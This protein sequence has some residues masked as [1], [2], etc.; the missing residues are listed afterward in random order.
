MLFVLLAAVIWGSSFPVINY[1]LRDISP[2]LFLTLRFT[3]AFLILLPFGS[4]SRTLRGLFH[5]DLFLLS[6]PSVLAFI[7]QFKGQ[8]LTTASKAALFVNSTPVH[9]AIVSWL[10]FRDR[11][12]RRQVAATVIALVGVVVTSTKLDFSTLSVI[13]RGD[14]YCAVVGVCWGVFIVFSIPVVKKY[15]A[16]QLSR[17]LYFWTAVLALPFLSGEEMRF[18]VAALPAVVYL[19]GVTT[20]LAYFLYLKG[21]AR[22]SSLST[23]IIILVEVVVAFAI[24]HVWLGESFTALE[25][26]GVILV[27]VG[28]TMVPR[29]SGGQSP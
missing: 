22:V 15:G 1:S 18:G 4:P 28:V 9:V 24:S 17:A 27:M 13:N 5:R 12:S 21:V 6:I 16:L 29:K 23:S 3:G 25:T 8:E 2:V 14:V 19:A 7:L 26:V 10:V 11:F 20:V